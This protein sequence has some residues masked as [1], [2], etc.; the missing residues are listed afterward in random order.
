MSQQV[1]IVKGDALQKFA[2]LGL[3]VG[4]ILLIVFNFL[5]PR[6]D[7]ANMLDFMTAWGNKSGFV[8]LAEMSEVVGWLGI[9]IGAVGVY[10][11][12]TAKGSSWARLGF[13][14]AIVGTA[15]SVASSTIMIYMANTY[16]LW[17]GAAD[18]S[19]PMMMSAS[20]A[21]TMVCSAVFTAYIFVEWLAIAFLGIGIVRSQAYPPFFGW[22]ALVLGILTLA[23]VGVPL[24][25][26]GYTN[27]I[28]SSFAIM[29]SLTF[30]WA[31]SLGIWM[32]RKA[33]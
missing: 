32:A 31:L 21:V 23:V 28:Q 17:L 19:K 18:A 4:A 22:A 33:W 1:A 26:N 7:A 9:M 14:G 27:A 30:V 13:Y 6:A 16:S 5:L 25:V 8:K 10:R 20:V 3:V 24:F 12:V 2:S 15:L 29:A 11:S